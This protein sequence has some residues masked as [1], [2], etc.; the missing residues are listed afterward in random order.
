VERKQEPRGTPA[1]SRRGPRL[2]AWGVSALLAGALAVPMLPAYAQQLGQQFGQMGQQF[3]QQVPPGQQVVPPGQQFGAPGQQQVFHTDVALLWRLP[4]NFRGSVVGVQ[5]VARQV[6][7]PA[8]GQ[9]VFTLDDHRSLERERVLVVFQ[10]PAGAQPAGPMGLSPGA[11]VNV[12]GSVQLFDR[13]TANEFNRLFGIRLGENE[14]QQFLGRPVVV[15]HNVSPSPR[16][17]QPPL[18][19]QRQLGAVGAARP[20][21][22][23]TRNPRQYLNQQVTVDGQVTQVLGNNAAVLDNGLVVVSNQPFST[24]VPGRDQGAIL[25]ARPLTPLMVGDRM[26]VTGT[27]TPVDR[28]FFE[29]QLGIFLR[30]EAYQ[31][32]LGAPALVATSIQDV[33]PGFLTGGAPGGMGGMGGMAPFSGTR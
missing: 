29:M 25:S 3:G 22:E 28:Q 1:R 27:V 19:Q 7:N 33:Q 4:Q 2:Y 21:T 13:G 15:A 26:R 8:P 10:M 12:T 20:A 18:T 23:I 30:P 32:W 14:I 31:Q 17:G 5:G 24:L 11:L 16:L 9:W 6:V